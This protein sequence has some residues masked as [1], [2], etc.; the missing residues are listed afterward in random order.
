MRIKIGYIL[1]NDNWS[2]GKFEDEAEIDK[3][4]YITI[5][6]IKDLIFENC[7]ID[8]NCF[9]SEITEVTKLNN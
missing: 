6:M 5:D 2:D 7:N 8:K 1:D 9:I 3:Y 4:F